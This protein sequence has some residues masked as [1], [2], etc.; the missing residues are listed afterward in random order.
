MYFASN[1]KSYLVFEHE[2][3]EEY[4]SSGHKRA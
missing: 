4:N 3:H 2:A 1:A